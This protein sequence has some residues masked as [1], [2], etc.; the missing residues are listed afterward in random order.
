MAQ[1]QSK[2]KYD[3][4]RLSTL[5]FGLFNKINR[6]YTLHSYFSV[7]DSTTL[8]DLVT[9]KQYIDE[10]NNYCSSCGS[11]TTGSSKV[12]GNNSTSSNCGCS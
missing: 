6:L 5:L 12:L 10:I 3:L 8:A 7:I 9:Q 11:G 1:D 2:K 4:E